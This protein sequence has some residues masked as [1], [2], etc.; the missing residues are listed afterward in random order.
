MC[1]TCNFF[2]SYVSPSGELLSQ[3]LV[4]HMLLNLQMILQVGDAFEFLILVVISADDE[5]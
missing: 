2:I 3:A 5:L 1:K 4:P